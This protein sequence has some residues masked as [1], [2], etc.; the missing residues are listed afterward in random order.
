MN[1]L[2]GV[3][4]VAVAASSSETPSVQ[5]M[6]ELAASQA[7]QRAPKRGDSVGNG[8]LLAAVAQAEALVERQGLALDTEAQ[9]ELR[10]RLIDRLEAEL[11]RVPTEPG[12][13]RL[14]AWE[15]LVRLVTTSVLAQQELDAWLELPALT[16]LK[17]PVSGSWVQ[18]TQLEGLESFP[19]DKVEVADEVGFTNRLIDPGEWVALNVT[20]INQTKL[21]WFSTS[22]T[23]RGSGCLWVDS[24]RSTLVGE[25]APG[26]KASV[27]LWAYVA[28][29]CTEPS[30]L[31]LSLADTHR[32]NAG[33][34]VVSVTSTGFSRPTVAQLH[35]DSDAL[36]SS[37]G[38]QLREVRPN[39]R[40]ELSSDLRVPGPVTAVESSWA[41]PRAAGPLFDSLTFRPTPLV[42]RGGG[43]FIAGDDLDG[44]T[45]DED[46]W[47]SVAQVPGNKRWLVGRQ[48]GRLWLALDT[49]VT[50]APVVA[51]P[52]PSSLK[53]ARPSTTPAR[54]VGPLSSLLVAGLVKDFVSLTPHTVQKN[55]PAALSAVSGYELLFDRVG[56]IAAYEAL[57]VQ[58]PLPAPV[59]PSARYVVRQYVAVPA[60]A[61]APRV[62][63]KPEPVVVE[64]EPEP[65]PPPRPEPKKETRL[66]AQIDAAG[67]FSLYSTSGTSA[68]PLLWRGNDFSLFPSFGVRAFIGPHVVGVVGLHYALYAPDTTFSQFDEYA[69]H[70][71][72]GYRFQ[73]PLFSVTPYAAAQF[74][75]RRYAPLRETSQYFGALLGVNARVKLWGPLGLSLDVGVPLIQG[76]PTLI[77]F[78]GG[79]TNIISGIGLRTTLGVS[80]AF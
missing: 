67:G 68:Q 42:A 30:T 27:R 48:S 28:E 26:A 59:E 33:R 6:M 80:L 56:F 60:Q 23:A 50:L 63:R 44:E 9:A 37:D 34:V 2:A 7:A 49:Q 74:R 17:E 77:G 41:L 36:G 35:L 22:A 58:P 25:F 78:N 14:D 55:E 40:F 11:R 66:F 64:E 4:V 73:W 24:T 31:T 12:P 10:Q 46:E 51:A 52:T 8:L 18:T 38:S 5:A 79:T 54:P 47:A 65:A 16:P 20:L 39:Q 29:G 71:G 21:P 15:R 19:V 13:Q 61:V 32:G 75:Y 57:L 69:A 62:E 3:V 43:L 53:G 70:L 1:V 76:A 45:V 72:V